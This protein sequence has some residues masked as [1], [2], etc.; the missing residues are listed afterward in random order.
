MDRLEDL[1][2][3]QRVLQERLN[4]PQRTANDAS[5]RQQYINQMALALHEETVEML[6]AT[7]YKD[8][9]LVPFG[10]KREQKIDDANFREEVVDLM[11]YVV[12]LALIA[13]ITSQEFY[14]RYIEKNKENHRRIDSGQKYETKKL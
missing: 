13:G 10:W 9:E 14:E 2:E 4:I 12:N 6:C 8:P 1:F 3:R 11:H 7:R 5:M